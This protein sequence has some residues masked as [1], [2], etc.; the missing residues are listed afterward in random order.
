MIAL[1]GRR[2]SRR[3]GGFRGRCGRV[4][5]RWS[6]STGSCYFE[7]KSQYAGKRKAQEGHSEIL[8]DFTS[9]QTDHHGR[10][11]SSEVK[12]TAIDV[13]SRSHG[14]DQCKSTLTHFALECQAMT[15]ECLLEGPW[16]H[17][18]PPQIIVTHDL[19]YLGSGFSWSCWSLDC[20]IEAVCEVPSSNICKFCK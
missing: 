6:K 19:T 14:A 2:G 17:F 20:R 7:P 4:W 12:L 13:T 3:I 8:I 10:I 16:S 11:V 5:Q 15:R 18:L 1:T 9:P